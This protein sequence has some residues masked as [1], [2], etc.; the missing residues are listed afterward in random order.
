MRP[1]AGYLAEL[2]RIRG[3]LV[4]TLYLG[5]F[6]DT[7][8]AEVTG[9]TTLRYAVHRN[10][11]TGKRAC[12]VLNLSDAEADATVRFAE[13]SSTR[14]QIVRPFDSP[15]SGISP[16]SLTIPAERLAIVVEE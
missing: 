8:G 1:I 13:P 10:R 9:P 5:Q 15:R 12:V 7:K 11:V 4:D 6:L 2:L 16:I 14:A 3:E